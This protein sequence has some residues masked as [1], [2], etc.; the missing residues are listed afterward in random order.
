MIQTREWVDRL[1][2]ARTCDFACPACG[3]TVEISG[4][5]NVDLVAAINDYPNKG[6]APTG[7]LSLSVQPPA[8]VI[9]TPGSSWFTQPVSVPSGVLM[10]S[11]SLSP[12]PDPPREPE[13]EQLPEP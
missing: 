3:A 4:G 8:P 5:V 11:H 7:V 10:F 1:V 13:P 9:T 12:A 2:M 6:F